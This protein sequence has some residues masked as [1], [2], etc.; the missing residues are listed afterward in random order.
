[1]NLEFIKVMYP[2]AT[3]SFYSLAWFV[4]GLMLGRH[5]AAKRA[6]GGSKRS[7]KARAPKQRRNRTSRNGQEGQGIELYVG[8]LSYD[9]TEKD[10]R[11]IF[12]RYGKVVSVRIIRNTYNDKSKGFG[13]VRMA[14]QPAAD[15][16]VNALNDKEM[17]G[18]KMVVNEA[19]TK[20]R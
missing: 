18:R 5:S 8:N 15:A 9:A 7:G 11:Q 10:M 3:V 19:K 4:L 14:D 20:A 2:T 16:A 13:F 12:E 17:K 1:M 6:A